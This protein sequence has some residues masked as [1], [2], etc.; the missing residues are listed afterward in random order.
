MGGGM[1]RIPRRRQA[2]LKSGYQNFTLAF[3]TPAEAFSHASQLHHE[4]PIDL[5][6]L[7]AD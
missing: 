4:F 1:V 7:S 2:D 6:V 3:R 5:A